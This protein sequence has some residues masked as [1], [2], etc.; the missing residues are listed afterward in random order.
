L[1][2]YVTF[3]QMAEYWLAVATAYI[4]EAGALDLRDIDLPSKFH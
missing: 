4:D 1:V 3:S 2:G